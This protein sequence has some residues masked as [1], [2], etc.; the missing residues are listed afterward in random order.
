MSG[1]PVAPAAAGRRRPAPTPP[2]VRRR[3]LADRPPGRRHRAPVHDLRPPRAHRAARPRAPDRGVRAARRPGPQRRRRSAPGARDV[4]RALDATAALRTATPA[5]S[6]R[7]RRPRGLPQPSVPAA[8]ARQAFTQIG[9]NMVIYG[10][11]VI[12]LEATSLEHRGQPADPDLPRA[13]GAVLGRRRRLR[14]PV[15]QAHVLVVTNVLRAARVR[16]ACSSSGDN[17]AAILLL[18]VVVSTI[19]VFFGPA[20][21]AMIPQLVPR[22]QLLA[23]N[24]VFTLTLNAAFALGFA[25]LGPDRRH[26][27][28]RPGADPGRRRVLPRRGRVL[29]DAAARPADLGRGGHARAASTHDAEE[30]MGSTLVA[31]ARGHRR[32]SAAT[33]RSAGRCMYLG[34]AASLVGVLGVLGPDFATDSLGLAA[35]GLRRRRAAAR[36][37]D[38]D[39]D[40]AAQLV[41][42]R[43]SRAAGSSRAAS[44]RSGS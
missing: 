33:G 7:G 4:R 31:A 37:R 1:H 29:L 28:R 11:T 15:R 41:R 12:I 42:T 44:S 3:H 10:L 17:L 40:P 22:R 24:G 2:S 14:R 9:G 30:A 5:T 16:A 8:L 38:R 18:N 25:L 32:S 13:G 6:R 39:R 35:Q 27:R 23:A 36:V 19:T 20:E 34:I 43:C 26:A 21:A